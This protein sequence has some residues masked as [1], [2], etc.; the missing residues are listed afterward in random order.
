MEGL[1][2]G[3]IRELIVSDGGSS[4]ATG[5]VAQ[6]WGAEV[7]EGQASRGGQLRRGC[8]A[9]KGEWLL[10]LHADTILQPGWSET[11]RRHI[12]ST[13]SAGW[14]KLRFNAGGMAAS[15]VA[16]WANLRSRAGLPYG[17]QGLLVS[18]ALYE[19]VG[20]YQDQPLMEDVALALRLRRNLMPLN[21]YAITSADKYQRNGWVRQGAKNL[22]TLLRYFAGRDAE[23]LAKSYR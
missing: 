9:A 7:I 6:A 2:A 20:G 10:I 23:I 1:D 19:Q 12:T 16:G 18:H 15:I 21:G 4:D 22:W 5:A 8:N 17:D 14:F 3:L 11:V 13:S